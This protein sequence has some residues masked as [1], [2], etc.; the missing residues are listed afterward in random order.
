MYDYHVHS[1]YSDGFPLSRMVKAAEDSVLDGIGFTDHCNVLSRDG[2]DVN[3]AIMGH[4]LDMNYERRREGIIHL[5]KNTDIR[6][7]DAAE[8]DYHPSSQDKIEKFLHEV[9]FD[10]TLGSVHYLNNK[11]IQIYS[12]FSDLSDNEL[13]NLAQKYYDMIISLINSDLFDVVSHIDLIERNDKL[14]GRVTKDEFRDVAHA[15]K[16]SKTIPEI[17]VGAIN[18]DCGDFH[19]RSDFLE[20]LLENDIEFTIGTDSHRPCEIKNRV[21]KMQSILEE[22]GIDPANPPDLEI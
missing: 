13:D 20:I 7:F 4:N 16:N 19:P 8:V 17:N 15:L 3:R 12:D 5:Q 18:A 9:G 21:T 6:I 22:Y 10:Y 14:S 1:N 2:M 11:N